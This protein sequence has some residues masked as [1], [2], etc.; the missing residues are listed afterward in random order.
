MELKNRKHKRFADLYLKDPERIGRR[1]YKKVYPT[2]KNNAT[3]DVNASRLLKNAKV[4]EYIDSIEMKTTKEVELSVS[5]VKEKL[6]RFSEAKI[7]D[8]FTIKKGFIEV[9]DFNKIP[10]EIIDCIQEI[11]QTKDGIKI[12]LVDKKS[13]VTDIGKVFGMFTDN[14]HLTGLSFA[15]ALKKRKEEIATGS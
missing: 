13:S 9:K 5:W 8:Y 12:K 14:I 2:V 3:A 7:T 1:A 15:E 10:P 6:K 11:Q 4:R